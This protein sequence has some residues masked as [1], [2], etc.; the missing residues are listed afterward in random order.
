MVTATR[1]PGA[2]R[3]KAK[4]PSVEQKWATYE[5][6]LVVTAHPDDA[7]F[8]AGGTIAKL[9]DM[10]L[11]VTL[12]VATSG[13]KGT[14]DESLRPQ[15]LA[16]MREAEQRAAAKV[17][18]LARVVFWGMPD[19]FLEET[20]E[21]RG[22]VVKLIRSLKPDLMIT[23]D[24]YRPGFNHTDHRVIGRVVRDA[25]FP[26]AHDPLYYAHLGR[27][28]IGPHRTAELLLAGAQDPD[29]HV[30]IGPYLERKADAIVCHTSQID[31]R[32]REEI[33]KNWAGDPRRRRET[34]KRTGY[35][36]AESFRRIEF[37]R[38][39]GA[40]GTPPARRGG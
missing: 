2:A 19:G 16:A 37:R 22:Q 25:L 35:E 12:C 27:E 5:R 14:R 4:E 21:L 3:G 10:G 38:P 31:G 18:G 15:E 28:G 39:P 36:Y 8:L 40:P 26:A 1:R 7:E 11:R 30:D 13:D 29:Y 34:K 17:L 23:W 20:H 24:G 32:T 6:A 9:C 33:L